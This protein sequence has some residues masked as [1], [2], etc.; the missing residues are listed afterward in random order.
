MKSRRTLTLLVGVVLLVAIG[1][2]G[3]QL[4]VPYAAEG[5]GPTYNTL[6]SVGGTEVISLSGRAASKATGHLNMT[7]VSVLDGLDVFTAI[8]GWLQSDEAVVPRSELFPPGQ[9]NQQVE[10]TQKQD[11][12]VSQIHAVSAALREL[13]YPNRLQVVSV[14]DKSPSTGKLEPNDTITSLQ[15]KP[16]TDTDSILTD[17]SR[18]APGTPVTVGYTRSGKAGT[19]RI[20]TEKV[21]GRRGASLGIRVAY[22]PA[23]PFTVNVSLADVGGPSAGLMF[24]LGIIA[25]AGHTDLAAG[26]FIAGTGT[27]S[28]AGLVGPIGGIPLKMIAARQA[29]ATVFLVPAANCAEAVGHHPSGLELVKVSTLDGA[30]HALAALRAGRTPASCS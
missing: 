9:S 10:Q 14:L 27:I 25:K 15:G 29:G 17:L 18:I 19:A 2:G 6:G 28:P 8:K 12:V 11:F 1:V 3:S 30:L 20:V 21:S 13:G 22:Q 24:T 7:T 16:V 4:P 26:R 23:A 5:P